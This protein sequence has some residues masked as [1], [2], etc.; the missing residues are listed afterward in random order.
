MSLSHSYTQ[1]SVLLAVVICTAKRFPSGEN[2]GLRV[3]GGSL[4][5]GREFTVV[6]H[7]VDGDVRAPGASRDIHK[8][9][10]IRKRE[11]RPTI[12]RGGDHT[13]EN[14]S[15]LAGYLQPPEIKRHGEQGAFVQ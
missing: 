11:L 2:A 10:G 15:G 4:A 12:L 14:R 8:V 5:E 1:M 7:P 6:V 9:S 13:L 3:V